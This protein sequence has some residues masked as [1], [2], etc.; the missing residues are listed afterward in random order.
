MILAIDIGNSAIKFAFF[1]TGKNTGGFALSS[2]TDRTED[3]YA[4]IFG[5]AFCGHNFDRAAVSS[6]VPSLT[7]R[8]C[9]A[10]K[11]VTGK[12]P[13][14]IGHG[15]RTGLDIRTDYQTELGSD[16]VANCVAA[17]KM[18]S[19]AYIVV[20]L[21]TATTLSC[22]NGNRVFCG[23]MIMPGVNAGLDSLGKTCANLPGAAL[24]PPKG[25]L[26]KNTADS[27]AGG[28]VYGHAAMIDG[29]IGRAAEERPGEKFE[30]FVTGGCAGEVA[31]YCK[32]PLR[33]VPDLTLRGIAQIGE[34]NSK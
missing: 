1:E 34:L 25:L 8:V 3:E 30:V 19:G 2:L 23:V 13:L 24:R 15:V 17:G 31:P 33:H 10:V 32:T 5:Q 7:F 26:G 4:M 9:S 29:L 18:T 27:V 21:G 20:D 14:V 28:V 11:R 6:V 16:I 22:V 12:D